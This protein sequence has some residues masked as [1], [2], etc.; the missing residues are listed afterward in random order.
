MTF[1]VFEDDYQKV[2]REAEQTQHATRRDA[3]ATFGEV[4]GAAYD[5][6]VSEDQS[7]SRMN[8]WQ[9]HLRPRSRKAGE[10]LG[11][12]P[13]E[14]EDL[15]SYYYSLTRKDDP[16]AKSVRELYDSGQVTYDPG[17]NTLKANSP[18]A[19]WWLNGYT[20]RA[21]YSKYFRA[22]AQVQQARKID[23]TMASDEQIASQVMEKAKKIREEAAATM[24]RGRGASGVLGQFA[25]I[26]AGAMTDP[27]VIATLPL[28]YGTVQAGKTTTG[29]LLNVGK[30]MGVEGLVEMGIEGAL[31]QPSVYEFK[32]EIGSPYG[33]KEYI[34]N[35][36]AAGAGAAAF[37]GVLEGG[38]Q[39]YKSWLKSYK[40]A[41]G[42]DATAQAVGRFIDE[43]EKS[44]LNDTPDA[45]DA[46]IA[47][48]DKAVEDVRQGRTADVQHIVEEHVPRETAAQRPVEGVERVRA[49]D[50]DTDAAR[51]QY[52]SG[53]DAQGV[54]ERLEGVTEWDDRL[55][56]ISLFY[57]DADGKLFVVDG[58]QRLGLAKRLD[59]D[60]IELTG[61]RMRAADGVTP[62][63]A[64]VVA[65]IKNIAEG[66]G[67]AIDAAKVL[68]DT[69]NLDRLPQ[70]PPKSALVRQAQG[71]SRLSDDAFM[72]VVNDV[73]PER[74]AAI[75][76]DSLPDPAEQAAAI[77]VLAKAQPANETQARAMVQ[78]VKAAGFERQVT[79]DL[80]G[81]REIAESLVGEK[82]RVIDEATKRLRTDK[83]LFKS[84]VDNQSRI[85]NGGNVLEHAYNLEVA[86]DAQSALEAL[87]RLAYSR[88]PVADALTDAARAV[89]A[90]KRPASVL[91]DFLARV[92]DALAVGNEPGIAPGGPG[93]GGQGPRFV[94]GG[95]ASNDAVVPRPRVG[96][97]V[98]R[99][100][101]SLE[102]W[103]N[104][105][106]AFKRGQPFTSID[107]IYRGA[108]ANQRTLAAFGDRLTKEIDGVEFI[109]P[110]VKKKAAT[111]AKMKAK[112]KEAWEITD[113]VR[114][115]FKVDTPD[116]ADAVASRLAQEFEILD[117][118]WNTNGAGYFDRKL[119]V[120]LKD[121]TVAEVQ[122]W[123]PNMLRAK[124][125]LG[126]HL[127]YE[128]Q[129]ALMQGGKVP[130]DA[131]AEFNRLNDEM[132]KLYSDAMARASD[133]WAQAS[134]KSPA[135]SSTAAKAST[136]SAS[137]T[138]RPE[139]RT[140]AGLTSSQAPDS[141]TTAAA[142]P[143]P[144]GSNR[145]AGRPSQ[146]TNVETADKSIGFTSNES[147]AQ[148][149]RIINDE[150]LRRAV[151][152][153]AD[154]PA[155]PP[156]VLER[157]MAQV[158]E[159]LERGDI[160][161][162]DEIRINPDTGD[163]EM[164]VR[165]AREIFEELDRQEKTLAEI[166]PCVRG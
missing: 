12:D 51:F 125:E 38:V 49:A 92:R 24:Q 40:A 14:A 88:G 113:V 75:I 141:G 135:S 60:N 119:M 72:Q 43:L 39:G 98:V 21:D 157:E 145:T 102:Q 55:A 57:E 85:E 53:A 26:A 91:P 47:A 54:T 42:N 50:L 67:R 118:S 3:A 160:D 34:Q 44:R 61:Y 46:H 122:M 95:S 94:R 64:R 131:L 165:S 151:D 128:Q 158:R 17:T 30:A 149:R 27:V 124:E 137:S 76:G 126:G 74:Y 114:G 96:D 132:V 63:Q 81:E 2:I 155:L 123:E 6:F 84:L 127:L 31:I 83:R 13:E 139:S 71:L 164:V 100:S 161:L 20:G 116:A 101:L 154:D 112:R 110:G 45:Q 108:E 70:L 28:G 25:G 11:V 146:Y 93:R 120:R 22:Y 109:D 69:G 142:T 138:M 65:A 36:L 86:N 4:Y 80:F 117:E 19:R 82:A 66:S 37:R 162:P 130:P 107:D 99:T 48:I 136:K 89:K 144:A 106:D 9:E 143:P 58:H 8:H 156:E 97:P 166:I 32:Q 79:A 103:A 104:A 90:G 121:G 5:A 147:L 41:K 1:S 111:K 105:E 68:R 148:T 59:P 35:V 23:P 129:R 78:Q 134:G 10:L 73:V 33:A 152:P 16:L 163:E 77:Q 150:Q 140:S 133:D 115:G 18:R 7:T 15:G 56:G 52:K 62:E 29:T 153:L 87:G 159:L